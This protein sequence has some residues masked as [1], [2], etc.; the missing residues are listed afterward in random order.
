M[1]VLA[2]LENMIYVYQKK[3]CVILRV[4]KDVAHLGIDH[5][6]SPT[7]YLLLI[8]F[9]FYYQEMLVLS[10]LVLALNYYKYPGKVDMSHNDK[11]IKVICR[12][13]GRK[14][15][16]FNADFIMSCPDFCQ[17]ITFYTLEKKC[18]V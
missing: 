8:D 4:L 1:I 13:P 11:V 18:F 14:V 5:G 15:R 6:D 12:Y 9:F 17:R 2:T 16:F 7:K 3:L 10:I